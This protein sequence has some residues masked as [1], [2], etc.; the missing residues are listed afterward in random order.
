MQHSFR[1]K[2]FRNILHKMD[3]WSLRPRG[4]EPTQWLLPVKP[5][6]GWWITPMTGFPCTATQTIVVTYLSRFSVREKNLKKKGI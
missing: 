3:G 2:S 5:V 4:S 6:K 1:F